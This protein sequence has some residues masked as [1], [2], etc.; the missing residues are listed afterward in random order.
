MEK[1]RGTNKGTGT[2]PGWLILFLLILAVMWYVQGG[3]LGN[4]G[5]IMEP[6]SS[7][8]QSPANETITATTPPPSQ[9]I[10]APNESPYKNQVNIVADA[11]HATNPNQEYITLTAS[12]G[13]KESIDITGWT[14]TNKAGTVIKI[15]QGAYL[16]Y[17]AQVNPQTDIKLEPGGKALLLTGK[18]PIAT[19]FQINTCTGY[20]SQFQS[21]FPK[22]P[23][24]C[25]YPKNLIGLYEMRDDA[26]IAYIEKLPRC[27]MPQNI[28][29][30]TQDACRAVIES[31]FSYAGCVANEG[32]KEKFY[33][34]EWRV[35]LNKDAK[36][37]KDK[38]EKITLTDRDGKTVDELSY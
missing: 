30:L 6:P 21:F 28:P 4:N 14:L 3:R 25:P 13:N 5:I 8:N 19:S 35:Y 7:V 31:N 36:L 26:C 2:D 37:W 11:V 32:N 10:P 18:S 20:F 38:Y 33:S 15:G 12:Y 29:L 24:Q 22:L 23:E 9:K 27:R 17:S 34:K 16:P 1:S